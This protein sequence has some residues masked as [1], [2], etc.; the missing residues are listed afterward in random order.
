MNN[1]I[2][3]EVRR[4]RAVAFGTV[5]WAA[6]GGHGQSVFGQQ[7]GEHDAHAHHQHMMEQGTA[8]EDPHAH[9]RHMMEKKG[10]ERSVHAYDVPD[11]TLTGMD[12]SAIAL[13]DILNGDRPV[14]LNFI[15]TTCTT[16]CPVLSATFGQVREKMGEDATGVRFVSIS[17][18]PEH[19]TPAKLR[20]YAARFGA[21]E[22]WRFLTGALGDVIATQKAFDAYRG[23]KMNH[24]PLTFFR[25]EGQTEWVRIAGFASAADI[26]REYRQPT[27]D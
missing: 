14:M 20:E 7:G 17:I 13:A 9:H 12:E 3:S 27:A 10:Y 26:V 25:G 5:F 6:L 4:L 2:F 11:V 16:I 1:S 23:D 24:P 8:A 22:G 21:G 18:D 15:F 19:D